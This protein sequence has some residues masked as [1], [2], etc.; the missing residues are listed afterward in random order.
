VPLEGAPGSRW[1]LVASIVLWPHIG[2]G[3]EWLDLLV[4]GRVGERQ[5]VLPVRLD[6]EHGDLEVPE[7]S[8]LVLDESADSPVTAAELRRALHRPDAAIGVVVTAELGAFVVLEVDLN[9]AVIG[10]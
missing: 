2:P 5:S 4:V 8:M 3:V 7:R 9:P 1:Q 6:D 10:D